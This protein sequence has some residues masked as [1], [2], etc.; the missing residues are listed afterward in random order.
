MSRPA[1]W[2]TVPHR[3]IE[4]HNAVKK[5]RHRL[6]KEARTNLALFHNRPGTLTEGPGGVQVYDDEGLRELGFSTLA[7][8][9]RGGLSQLARALKPKVSPLGID[10]KTDRATQGLAPLLDGIFSSTQFRKRAAKAVEEAMS[11]AE[12]H[13]LIEDDPLKGG[14]VATNLDPMET[15]VTSTRDEVTTVRPRSR[16]WL[17]AVYAKGDEPKDLNLRD[18]IDRL[19][20]YKPEPITGVTAHEAFAEEDLV[21]VYEGY[22]APIG[23]GELAPG[24]H[25]IQ[26]EGSFDV[27]FGKGV[28][29]SDEWNKLLPVVSFCW[30]E[31]PRGASDGKPLGRTLAPLQAIEKELHRK[32]QDVIDYYVPAV[33]NAPEGYETNDIPFKLL[34]PGEDGKSITV[35][36]PPG[37]G[38]AIAE[39]VQDVRET[40]HRASGISEEAAEGTAPTQLKSGIALSNWVA[41][42][43]QRLSQQHLGYQEMWLQAARIH[44]A[45]GPPVGKADDPL[46]VQVDWELLQ[47][48]V[49]AYTLSFEVVNDVVNH[50]PFRLDLLEKLQQQG[51]IS[52]EK[53]LSHIEDGNVDAVLAELNSEQ[54]Y[55]DHQLDKA[56]DEGIVEPP[57]PFQDK[58]KLADAAAKAWMR[59]RAAKVKPPRQHLEALRI[60]QRLA[61]GP[62]PG[63][64]PVAS[65]GVSP[66]P[67][68]ALPAPGAGTP[69]PP[70]PGNAVPPLT[71]QLPPLATQPQL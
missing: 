26:L 9:F 64:Q 27:G 24:R 42:V 13:V 68:N 58:A 31:G 60:L 30:E 19:P 61:A 25:V 57:V 39:Y 65:L 22:L 21:A 62:G 5:A 54:S 3:L 14:R 66:A 20:D 63:A 2:S 41:I 18:A 37:P 10:W 69:L 51:A 59:L 4:S 71:A 7:E 50:L 43:N 28:L 47:L 29:V 17:K 46:S 53:M 6:L 70:A 38:P 23:D 33:E 34:P 12:G 44:V 48:P 1:H 16:R 8:C 15:F 11:C 36:Y 67:T 32:R 52:L 55:I 35:K 49:T 45:L 40:Q 56:I